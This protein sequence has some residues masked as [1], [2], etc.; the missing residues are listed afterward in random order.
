MVVKCTGADTGHR[1]TVCPP[2]SFFIVTACWRI[3][4]SLD[5][6][7]LLLCRLIQ[8]EGSAQSKSTFGLNSATLYYVAV[9]WSFLWNWNLE[10]VNCFMSWSVDYMY[11]VYCCS[12]WVVYQCMARVHWFSSVHS[13]HVTDCTCVHFKCG[14]NAWYLAFLYIA[15]PRGRLIQSIYTGLMCVQS[16]FGWLPW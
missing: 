2:S 14:D 1:N 9:R 7:Y 3:C 15:F 6:Q 13:N 10:Y 4:C 16:M 11:L 5:D 12:R 8:W